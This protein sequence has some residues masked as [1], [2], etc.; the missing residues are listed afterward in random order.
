MVMTAVRPEVPEAGAQDAK[1]TPSE[2]WIAQ[3]QARFPTERTVDEALT[4]KLRSRADPPYRPST[5]ADVAAQLRAF[6][7]IHAPGAEV[8]AVAPLGGGASKEQYRFTLHEPGGA[9]MDY[10]L[11]REP[12][13]SV[14]ETHRLREFEVMNAVR[15]TIPVPPARWV[16]AD[17]AWFGRPSLISGFVSGVTK[18]AGSEGNVSGLGTGFSPEWQARLAPQ[19]VDM[20]AAIHRFDWRDAALGAFDVPPQ[21]SVEGVL[22]TINWWDRVWEEDS[23]EAIPI[24]RFAAQWLRANAPPIERVTLVHH[25]FRPGNFLFEPDSGAITAVLDWELAHLGDYHEDLAWS[26]QEGYGY[27]DAQG[28]FMVC[29]LIEREAFFRRYEQASGLRVDRARIDYYMIMNTWKSAVIVLATGIRCAAGGKSHQDILLSWLA[30]FGHVCLHNLA[31]L[32]QE[33]RHGA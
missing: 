10:V 11:R 17:G 6:F 9:P 5:L 12:P 33:A 18:P 29:G 22:R 21:G 31:R 4:R 25:D 32:L 15:G 19:F 20:L 30:G 3:L 26:L 14:V 16:D 24:I 27:T 1:S 13:E 28:R 23:I 8:Q 2:A 7:A